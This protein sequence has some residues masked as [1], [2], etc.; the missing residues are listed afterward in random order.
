MSEKRKDK[1]G[2]ILKDGESQRPDGRYCFKYKNISGKYAYVYAW[3]LTSTDTTPNGKRDDLCLRDKEK[4]ISED[5]QNGIDGQKSKTTTLNE[6]FEKSL[7][8]KDLKKSSE[9]NYRYFYNHFVRDKIGGMSVKN[10]DF[11]VLYSFYSELVNKHHIQIRTIELINSF[12]KAAFKL[13]KRK[14]LINEIPTIEALE[15]LK[16]NHKFTKNKKH[17]LTPEE[18]EAFVN[19]VKNSEQFSQWLPLFT[20]LLGTGCRINELLSLTINDVDFKS[21]QININH[22]FSYI[23]SESGKCE[24][25]ITT[26]KTDTSNRMIPMFSDVE[27]A[28]RT[29]LNKQAEY[30]I[31]RAVVDG[32]SGFIFTNTRRNVH[33]QSS[34]YLL[35]ERICKAYNEQEEQ[36]AIE[37]NRP[38][39]LLPKFS[40]HTFRHT[41]ASRYAELESNAKTVQEI[42]GHADIATT[43]NIYSEISAQKKHHSFEHI[44][45][46][47]KL[48]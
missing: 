36:Q 16:S 30:G 7:S 46:K 38:P 33:T 19:F 25:H 14:K 32:Y 23:R 41:F 13:A 12:L 5:L 26:P 39:L 45:G 10:I 8:M 34:V 15:E 3:K 29:E 2:R 31:N 40:A 20:C 4:Q 44:E 24:L 1:R 37:E 9:S 28:I 42:L 17:A 27:Q 43:M 11:E 22:T 48:A 21:K 35:I 47:M 18:T 6:L